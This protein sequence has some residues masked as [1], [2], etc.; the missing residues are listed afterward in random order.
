MYTA[1]FYEPRQKCT[2]WFFQ[3]R[4][5][6]KSGDVINFI[7]VACRNFSRLKWYKNCKN[8]LRLAKVIVKNKMSRFYGS[9]CI[10]IILSVEARVGER[11]YSLIFLISF[12]LF[13][14]ATNRYRR[15]R[16]NC[17]IPW[18]PAYAGLLQTMSWQWHKQHCRKHKL[19]RY[20]ASYLYCLTPS[21]LPKDL[22]FTSMQ[23]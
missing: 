8:R 4:C 9:L 14:R 22:R 19:C 17:P 11:G 10:I 18:L 13:M 16:P 7:R 12:E 2:F 21:R 3:V 5:A 23:Q 1:T 15:G 6:Q 20:V